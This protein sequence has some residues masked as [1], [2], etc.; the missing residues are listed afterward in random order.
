MKKELLKDQIFKSAWQLVE[1]QGMAKLNVRK[2]ARLTGCS[3][4]SIYNAFDSFQS[5]QV[6]INAKILS[7]LYSALEQVVNVESQGKKSLRELLKELGMEYFNF[8]QTNKF[9]WKSLFEFFPLEA[10]PEWYGVQ[11]REGIYALCLKLSNRYGV[12][13]AQMKQ[14]IGFF[15]SSVHGMTSIFLNK[16]MDMVAE[17]INPSCIESYVEYCLDGLFKDERTLVSCSVE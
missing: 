5:L 14:I 12:P 10:L 11:A 4:G 13:Q 7:K 17:L 3:L 6:H 16:K 8:A 9:L 1:S 2:I 15:W